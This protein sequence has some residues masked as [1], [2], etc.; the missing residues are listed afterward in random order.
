MKRSLLFVSLLLSATTLMAQAPQSAT[1]KAPAKT[2]STA[3]KATTTPAKQTSTTT[4]AS[5]NVEVKFNVDRQLYYLYD[6]DK[7]QTV[8]VLPY[9][10]VYK[11]S[12]GLALVETKEGAGFINQSGKEIV[13]PNGKYDWA[14]D[15][16]QGLACVGTNDA[17]GNPVTAG[18]INKTGTL[19]IPMTFQHANS[20]REG[21]APVKKNGKWGYINTSGTM[22]IPAT[23]EDAKRFAYGMAAVSKMVSMVDEEEGDEEAYNYPRYGYITK[24]GKQLIPFI[25]EEAGDFRNTGVDSYTAIVESEYLPCLI[26]EKGE[27]TNTL[28][29]MP[30]NTTISQLEWTDIDGYDLHVVMTGALSAKYYGVYSCFANLFLIIPG[31]APA[32]LMREPNSEQQFYLY[33]ENGKLGLVK[34]FSASL[35]PAFDHI[36]FENRIILA[37]SEL[38]QENQKLVSAKISLFDLTLK[39]LSTHIYES[40]KAFSEDLAWVKREG[41]VGFINPKGVEVI[42]PAYDNATP[43][44]NGFAT[45]QK[46]NKVGVINKKADVV[47]PFDYDDIGP[48]SNGVAY[49]KQDSLYGLIDTTGKKR[50]DATY[51]GLGNVS[52]GLVAFLKDNKLGF[53]N[54][55]GDVVIQPTF[56]FA[57]SFSEGL[58]MV[59]MDQ[60]VGF[61]DKLGTIVIP[62][63]YDNAESFKDGCALVV[64]SGNFILIDKKGSV[65]KTYPKK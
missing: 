40:I 54:T 28:Y 15:F 5:A 20:F 13:S 22:V 21:L 60:R 17:E 50:L 56:D 55:K 32:Q 38:K 24:T 48:F 31:Y 41:K 2:T 34:S 35:E 37:F 18:F 42:A 1:P 59:A 14:A 4:K 61:I 51:E 9:D 25:Y 39:P 62:C 65:I 43:F 27:I 11:F 26:D 58:A 29:G 19:A 36:Q 57:D 8:K 53:I 16:S 6:V 44:S 45:V 10:K 12:E 64:E 23:Y 52:E 33:K 47:I 3:A 30:E 7:K 46:G 49:F 63:K